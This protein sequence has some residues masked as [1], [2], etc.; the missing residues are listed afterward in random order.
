MI[1]LDENTDSILPYG[2]KGT[3]FETVY[4]ALQAV[5]S[6][7]WPSDASGLRASIGWAWY[8]LNDP[9]ALASAA[10]GKQFLQDVLIS[11]QVPLVKSTQTQEELVDLLIAWLGYKPTFGLLEA[12]Y[13]PYAAT[14]DIRPITDED[15]QAI[16]PVTPV[17]GAFY[18]I[19][20][21]ID[22]SRPLTLAE[23]LTIAER[24]TPMGSKPFVLYD[25]DAPTHA[26]AELG[27]GDVCIYAGS[28][29]PAEVPVP[30]QPD[31][32]PKGY[33]VVDSSGSIQHS[34][35]LDDMYLHQ[36]Q[37][38]VEVVNFYF[39]SNGAAETEN[40]ELSSGVD[41][42]LYN[43]DGTVADDALYDG[44]GTLAYTQA[45]GNM[46]E[47]A[48][49]GDLISLQ[50][51]ALVMNPNADY[52]ALSVQVEKVV[53]TTL[54]MILGLK[55]D[56]DNDQWKTVAFNQTPDD[57]F[58]WNG[59]LSENDKTKVINFGLS[60]ALDNPQ[61]NSFGNV[62]AIVWNKRYTFEVLDIYSDLG[63]TSVPGYDL[64]NLR[65]CYRHVNGDDI[66]VIWSDVQDNTPV[67]ACKYRIKKLPSL[68]IVVG[69]RWDTG[70]NNWIAPSFSGP[71]W[72]YAG[73]L[74]P[75]DITTLANFGL[76]VSTDPGNAGP[77]GN[78]LYSNGYYYDILELYSDLGSTISPYTNMS[79]LTMGSQSFSLGDILSIKN[80]SAIN[81]GLIMSYKLRITQN[82]R[83]EAFFTSA[84]A[85]NQDAN[86]GRNTYCYLYD[87]NGQRIDG[88]S[89]KTYTITGVYTA[90]GM[91][92]ET[93]SS[94]FISIS[95]SGTLMWY[96][97]VLPSTGTFYY[98]YRLTYT[99]S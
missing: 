58:W 44:E 77:N 5:A 15:T 27:Y 84:G 97:N 66:L 35:D 2:L 51:G 52:T 8:A 71:D 14:V 82:P 48:D 99:E 70:T 95:G 30:P 41:V 3:P 13:K 94:D 88:D 33:I 23:A 96:S 72:F 91:K 21:D 60:T 53:P 90:D 93:S 32:S 54:D 85:N 19:V 64:S 28:D 24:A 57:N 6:T 61:Y 89:S 45:N 81:S 18:V 62:G 86:V 50:S 65:T 22:L 9:A 34:I 49:G 80:V 74:D 76:N 67:M 47:A 63:Q 16:Y 68:E 12:L 98:A 46:F 83:K 29:V 20:T 37:H 1:K 26:Y 87:A 92:L 56:K 78:I 59:L 42:T 25:F 36:I 31:E 4:K 40:S 7:V 73:I 55:W 43:A 11:E 39:T 79:N 69:V 17:H 75:A 10:S 38:S